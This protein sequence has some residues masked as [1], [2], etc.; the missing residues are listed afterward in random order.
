LL[1]E[2]YSLDKS[3]PADF[4]TS[5]YPLLYSIPVSFGVYV[6]PPIVSSVSKVLP[7]LFLKSSS[8]PCLF[9]LSASIF[10][11]VSAFPKVK[12]CDSLRT[13]SL[14]FLLYT[15]AAL[16]LALSTTVLFVFESTSSKL[17]K[18]FKFSLFKDSSPS[19]FSKFFHWLYL[20]SDPNEFFKSVS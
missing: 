18:S 2:I 8:S 20:A 5:L 12:R 19:F 7:Y 14:K 10:S 6:L 13:S 3:F 11:D 4:T 15:S 16:F 17:N 9:C 1:K